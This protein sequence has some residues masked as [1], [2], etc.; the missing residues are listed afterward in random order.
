M[1]VAAARREAS[2]GIRTKPEIRDALQRAAAEEDR[3]ISWLVERITSD[4][5][6]EHGFLSEAENREVPVRDR[7][8]KTGKPD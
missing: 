3:S 1:F 6:K 8:R 4:W 5:L 7:K 2:I